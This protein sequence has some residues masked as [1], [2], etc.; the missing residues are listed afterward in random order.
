MNFESFQESINFFFIATFIAAVFLG[1]LAN[2]TNF[3]TMG[4]ISDV[5]N[6]NDY[7]R[8]RAWFL[9][10]AIAIL[11]V[12]MGATFAF[13]ATTKMHDRIKAAA[14]ICG[15]RLHTDAPDSPHLDADKIDGEIY[16][17]CSEED[18]YISREEIDSLEAHLSSTNINYRIEFFPGTVHGFYYPLVEDC[19][20]KP[21]TER[22]WERL[23]AMLHRAL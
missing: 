12:S 1:A 2:K 22:L 21:S 15:I 14:S 9:A 18:M 20:D 3:C 6:L 11:G 5:V 23:F 4:A 19:F 16:F 7:G 13:A 10:I 8:F 17:I